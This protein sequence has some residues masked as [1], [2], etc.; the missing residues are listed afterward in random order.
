MVIYVFGELSGLLI[1]MGRCLSHRSIVKRHHSQ[2][3]GCSF[4]CAQKDQ[5]ADRLWVEE[6][7]WGGP[8]GKG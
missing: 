2:G 8:W 7:I 6:G 1:G 4:L 5:R 3:S